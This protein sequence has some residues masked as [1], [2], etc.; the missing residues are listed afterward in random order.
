MLAKNQ[1]QVTKRLTRVQRRF[2]VWRRKRPPGTR[3]PHLLWRDAVELAL[4][5]GIHRAPATLRLDYYS[6]RA[7]VQQ[8]DATRQPEPESQQTWPHSAAP[9]TTSRLARPKS[10]TQTTSTRRSNPAG[11]A[12]AARPKSCTPSAPHACDAH[13]PTAFVELA[14]PIGPVPRQCLIEFETG[15]GNRLRVQLNG[16]PLADVIAL[17]RGLCFGDP[18]VSQFQREIES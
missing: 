2:E 16:S 6:L 15:Q 4:S 7:R 3:I 8:R 18:C 1:F 12:M 10:N 9:A 13:Q 17:G 11:P 14:T 5:L